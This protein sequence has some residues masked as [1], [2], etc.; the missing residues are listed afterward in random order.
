MF[1]V[2]CTSKLCANFAQSC[3][4][5]P[6]QVGPSC[7]QVAPKLGISWA[8]LVSSWAKLGQSLPQVGPSWRQSGANIGFHRHCL[9]FPRDVQFCIDFSTYWGSTFH[10]FR[11]PRQLNFLISAS[12]RIKKSHFRTFHV[13]ATFLLILGANMTP[14]TLQKIMV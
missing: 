10:G 11:T 4:N 2:H 13:N 12:A 3:S 8:K 5:L 1:F 6:P 7:A 14:K 9:P